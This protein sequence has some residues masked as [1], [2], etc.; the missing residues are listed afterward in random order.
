M[1]RQENRKQASQKPEGA[2]DRQTAPGFETD[3]PGDNLPANYHLAWK[4][5]ETAFTWAQGPPRKQNQWDEWD[6]L[7]ELSKMTDRR[8]RN[9]G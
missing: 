5:H 1:K 3:V 7:L 6:L 2:V 8:H 9:P 4:I